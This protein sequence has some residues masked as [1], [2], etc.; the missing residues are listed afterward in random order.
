MEP[1][2]SLIDRRSNYEFSFLYE[3][4]IPGVE[5]LRSRPFH[6]RAAADRIWIPGLHPAGF[7]RDTRLDSILRYRRRLRDYRREDLLGTEKIRQN[8]FRRFTGL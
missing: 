7:V 5:K 6:R 2:F 8:Q 1:A 4:Y 3:H